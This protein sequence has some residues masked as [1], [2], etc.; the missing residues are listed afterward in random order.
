MDIQRSLNSR[1][2]FP[3]R[4]FKNRAQANCSPGPILLPPAMSFEL[5]AKTVEE[6]DQEKCNFRNFG[7]S[8]TLSLERVEVTLV[9]ICGRGLPT[10]QT[11]LKSEELLWTYVRT[12]GHT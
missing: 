3:R 2:S 5:H 12:D 4:K 8:L 7:S 6:I 9:H 11:R 1:D 10:D